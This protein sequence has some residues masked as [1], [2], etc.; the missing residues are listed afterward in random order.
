MYGDNP[1]PEPSKLDPRQYYTWYYWNEVKGTP[2]EEAQRRYVEEVGYFL[3]TKGLQNLL[4]NP[5]K[6]GIEAKY[7][8][9][10]ERAIKNGASIAELKQERLDFEEMNKALNSGDDFAA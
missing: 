8:R 9:C 3:E 5:E 4:V 1:N 2:K 7:D 10:I 6:E